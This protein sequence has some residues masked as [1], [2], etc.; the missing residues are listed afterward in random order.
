MLISTRGRYVL[1]ILVDMA[2]T[3][4]NSYVPMRAVAARQGISLKYVEQLL[5][6]LRK[7][8]I[9]LASPG[10]GGGYRLARDPGDYSVAEILRLTEGGMT[11]VACMKEGSEPCPN[12]EKCPTLPMWRKFGQLVNGYFEGIS[13]KNLADGDITF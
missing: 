7:K 1:R 6:L 12:I 4:K 3:G 11:P 8:G 13:I 5:P 2:R 10:R 9:L